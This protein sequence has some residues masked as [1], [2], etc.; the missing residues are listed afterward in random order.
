MMRLL[1][2]LLLLAGCDREEKAQPPTPAESARLN[3]AEDMLN[4]LA[5]NEEGPASEDAG[6]SKS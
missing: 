3:E 4:D 6:P 1:P 2:L 5:K